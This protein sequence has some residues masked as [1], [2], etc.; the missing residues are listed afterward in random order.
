MP[1]LQTRIIAIGFCLFVFGPLLLHLAGV[2]PGAVDNRRLT[3]APEVS[4]GR[5]LDD[6]YWSEW[7]D[8]FADTFPLREAAIR[9]NL[10]IDQSIFDTSASTVVQGD[11]GWLYL[12]E[13]FTRLCDAT[14]TPTQ[15]V[16]RLVEVVD[17][18]TADGTPVVVTVTP[19]KLTIYPEYLDEDARER[20][21][22]T[23][24]AVA[25]LRAAFDAS[26]VDWFTPLWDDLAA[27]KTGG[28]VYFRKDTHW[29]DRG[30]MIGLEAMVDGVGGDWTADAVVG[31]G[32]VD[33]EGD[34]T[35]LTGIPSTEPTER[36]AV[37][38]P[39][40]EVTLVSEFEPGEDRIVVYEA[41][42]PE[43]AL[44]PGTTLVVHD[45]FFEPGLSRHLLEAHAAFAERTVYLHW[46]S[47]A[48][49]DLDGLVADA[50]RVVVQVA[51]RLVSGRV[52]EVFT[53]S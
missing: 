7:T 51:E 50:D 13:S 48:A 3:A 11:E 26:G 42:G 27:A 53:P 37:E 8:Y 39:G 45:S 12:D 9:A 14:L 31:V 41:S 40:V 24:E 6:V 28:A 29:T 30:A 52:E 35:R 16:D 34:L 10:R 33:W 5:V 22:C 18:W 1:R 25:E 46:D 32:T 4:P 21:E 2:R 47:A 44:L 15:A 36:L 43:G 17:G 38:R 19:N 23:D 49:V 20:A